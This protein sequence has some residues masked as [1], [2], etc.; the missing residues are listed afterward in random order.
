MLAIRVRFTYGPSPD[1][2]RL[3]RMKRSTCSFTRSSRAAS[4]TVL[5]TI[6][7]FAVNVTLP[8]MTSTSKAVPPE[9]IATTWN[10]TT[11]SRTNSVRGTTVNVLDSAPSVKLWLN[12][13]TSVNPARSSLVMSTSTSRVILLYAMS[14]DFARCST[15]DLYNRPSSM[16]LLTVFSVT[17]CVFF[18]LLGSKATLLGV[19]D[20]ASEPIS[21]ATSTGAHGSDS[22]FNE[23]CLAAA[24]SS[25]MANFVALIASAAVSSSWR[26][27]F[28]GVLV[29]RRERVQEATEV[30][31]LVVPSRQN[32]AVTPE[33]YAGSRLAAEYV[34]FTRC[35]VGSARS[36]SN[37]VTVTT[38]DVFQL[39]A[40][41]T[42]FAGATCTNVPVRHTTAVAGM[43]RFSGAGQSSLAVQNAVKSGLPSY[44]HVPVG[45]LNVTVTAVDAA[46][47]GTRGRARSATP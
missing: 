44:T 20:S 19:A 4:T 2:T 15:D 29:G 39:V 21:V 43:V 27:T 6:Q 22:M 35:S 17:V 30:S 40:L 16:R 8:G 11:R 37:A 46:P 41:N 47:A 36:S 34:T 26:L 12:L 9:L 13:G 14:S 10:V 3:F 5:G 7:F 33:S 32:G 25:C 38:C 42:R 31:L 1:T 45:L 18:Q 24:E 28:T 23:Y